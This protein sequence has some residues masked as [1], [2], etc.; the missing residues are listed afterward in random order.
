MMEPLVQSNS[1]KCM[2]FL[3]CSNIHEDNGHTLQHFR[4]NTIS[5][6]QFPSSDTHGEIPCAMV[7]C[8][9]CN[10]FVGWNA[11]NENFIILQSKLC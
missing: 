10:N 8:N 3:D 6:I 11:F 1:G 9:I 7:Y 2:R 4:T 5:Y